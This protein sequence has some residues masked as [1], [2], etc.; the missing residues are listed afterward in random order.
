MVD[1]RGE[2]PDI[3]EDKIVEH[4]PG[5]PRWEVLARLINSRQFENVA[6]IG[7]AHG[8]TV[9]RLLDICPSIKRYFCVDLQ[10]IKHVEDHLAGDFRVSWVNAPSVEAARFFAPECL[11]LVFVD[12]MH[13]Y[14]DLTEDI[15]AW[16]PKVKPQGFLCGHDYSTLFPGVVQAVHENFNKFSLAPD[17]HLSDKAKPEDHRRFVWVFVVNK[18]AC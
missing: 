1:W 13:E 3:P 14:P 9:K 18:E 17:T 2:L 8:D 15:E 11:D 5:Q 10:R 16:M 6:E 12:A 4:L 7:V